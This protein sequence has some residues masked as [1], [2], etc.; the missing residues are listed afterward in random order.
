[1]YKSGAAVK[2]E[3]KQLLLSLKMKAHIPSC[4]M[5]AVVSEYMSAVLDSRK[6]PNRY[7]HQIVFPLKPS[8]WLFSIKRF[9][10]EGAL[11]TL[12]HQ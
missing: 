6:T 12:V 5:S 7:L 8:R 2:K 3:K 10:E 11:F 4:D 1:M 9:I